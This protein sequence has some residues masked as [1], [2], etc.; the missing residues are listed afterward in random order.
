MA[1]IQ[2]TSKYPIDTKVS[3]ADLLIGSDADTVN[4]TKN[5]RIGDVVGLTLTS[6]GLSYPNTLI[7]G[8]VVWDTGLTY[9][10]SDLAYV[11]NN[12]ILTSTGGTAILSTADGS[13]PRVDI[14]AVDKDGVI[15]VVAGTPAGVPIKPFIDPNILT[16]VTTARLSALATVPDNVIDDLMYDE[17]TGSP[18]EWDVTEN[19]GIQRITLAYTLTT[20][21]GSNVIFVNAGTIGGTITFTSDGT[22]TFLDFDSLNFL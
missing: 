13:N 10:V 9:L 8:C 14:I 15:S 16:E 5:F 4:K 11:L 6:L 19:T 2:N 18:T 12:T 7:S 17:L 21:S 20:F 22:H 1:R 3:L